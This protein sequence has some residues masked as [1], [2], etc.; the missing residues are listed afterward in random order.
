MLD[1]SV[2][3]TCYVEADL[4]NSIISGNGSS[5][6]S[7]ATGT[8]VVVNSDIVGNGTGIHALSAATV[9]L[10][11]TDVSN[12]SITGSVSATYSNSYPTPPSGWTSMTGNL[13]VDPGYMDVS[14]AD[15][16]DWDL[17]LSATSPLRDA[18]DP[19]LLDADGSRSDV[20][21]YG[22]PLGSW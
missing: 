18:G 2:E 10:L 13:S 20:G 6:L 16:A 1:Y 14:S 5:G 3:S 11:N 21:G 8:G 7:L 22:G 12:N 19:S 4:T 17:T 9:T 15:P